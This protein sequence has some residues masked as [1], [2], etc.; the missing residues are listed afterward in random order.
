MPR[1]D[2]KNDLEY[3]IFLLEKLLE[4]TAITATLLKA[5]IA[6]EAGPLPP[7]PNLRGGKGGS[8]N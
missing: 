8:G 5:A 2:F 6:P 4:Q 3:M 7:M 1:I